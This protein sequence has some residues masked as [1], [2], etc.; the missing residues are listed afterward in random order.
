M[1]KV[2]LPRGYATIKDHIPAHGK[3]RKRHLSHCVAA[4]SDITPCNKIDKL[5]SALQIL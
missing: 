4:G 1:K 2:S 5:T 3:A